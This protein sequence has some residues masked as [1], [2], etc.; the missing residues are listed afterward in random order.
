MEKKK[1]PKVHLALECTPVFDKVAFRIVKQSKE[2]TLC[3]RPPGFIK[4][5]LYGELISS[6][7]PDLYT[8]TNGR[9]T[10]YVRG[11][12]EALDKTVMFCNRMEWKRIRKLVDAFNEHMNEKA[13]DKNKKGCK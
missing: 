12:D 3:L 10:L 8:K 6:T 1:K 4:Y 2:A 9:F 5:G 13:K 7:L 11:T